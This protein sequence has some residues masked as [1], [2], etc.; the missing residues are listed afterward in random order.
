MQIAFTGKVPKVAV[1][2]MSFN[3]VVFTCKNTH[4]ENGIQDYMEVVLLTGMNIKEHFEIVI[5]IG[6]TL[7]MIM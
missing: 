5:F 1:L 2:K 4:G 3:T 7:K 6:N